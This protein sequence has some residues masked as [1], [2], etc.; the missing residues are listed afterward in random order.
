MRPSPKV[1][2]WHGSCIDKSSP[3]ESLVSGTSSRRKSSSPR[4]FREARDR[5]LRDFRRAKT[6]SQKKQ[7]VFSRLTE[8][9]PNGVDIGWKS[10]CCPA[11]NE[12]YVV[13]EL[14][15]QACC[16]HQRRSV[17]EN[18]NDAR[19]MPP[20][21]TWIACHCDILSHLLD[22]FGLANGLVGRVLWINV[23]YFTMSWVNITKD[24]D[25]Y[26]LNDAHYRRAVVHLL[27]VLRWNPYP[28]LSSMM[29][30]CASCCC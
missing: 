21:E 12:L 8:T 20:H 25:Y 3:A 9:C 24:A 1:R 22:P 29:T 13:S 19:N 4:R 2:K 23:L 11:Y 10:T 17:L 28:S 26:L 15:L 18:V 30:I 27:S 7:V 14:E 6:L 5:L 16:I